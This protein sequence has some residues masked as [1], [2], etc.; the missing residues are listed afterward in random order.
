MSLLPALCLALAACGS[1]YSPDTYA[2]R[3]VQQAN[4]VEQGT[5]IGRRDVAISAEGSTGAAA[6]AAAGGVVGA[7]APGGGLASALAGVGGALVGGLVGSAAEH[8]GG[9]TRAFEY[10]VRTGGGLLSVTQRDT[11]PLAIGQKVLL[12]AGTQARIVPDYTTEPAAQRPAVAPAVEPAPTGAAGPAGAVP[13]IPP[14]PPAPVLVPAPPPPPETGAN[15]GGADPVGQ[16]IRARLPDALP[17]VARPVAAA[18][19][20]EAAEARP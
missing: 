1:S 19:A 8:V 13:G 12:I 5:V 11:V 2:T 10:V 20:N 16:A 6:G 17:P 9:D 14:A 7:A 18:L 15:S 3:A 4:K